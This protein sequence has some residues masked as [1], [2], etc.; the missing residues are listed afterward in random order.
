MNV[1][2]RSE[3]SCRRLSLQERVVPTPPNY[4]LVDRRSLKVE[5]YLRPL[6]IYSLSEEK[7]REKP[8]VSRLERLHG[9]CL[10]FGQQEITYTT[11][12]DLNSK[13]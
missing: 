10:K 4:I 12:D 6:S 7:A 1:F 3:D 9:L 13:Y 11:F 2:V 8:L 5:Y